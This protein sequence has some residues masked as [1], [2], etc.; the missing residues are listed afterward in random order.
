MKIKY[1]RQS[2]NIS[3]L[4]IS[5]GFIIVIILLII[6]FSIT[7]KNFFSF[8]NAIRILHTI[9]PIL[10]VSSGLALVIMAGKIDISVGSIAFLSNAIGVILLGRYH[11]P[12]YI[13][14]PSIVIVG[15]ILGALNGFLIVKLKINP[16]IATIGT[17]FI[18]RGL[19]LQMTNS[20]ILK[21]PEELQ[22]LGF[23]RVGIIFIDVIIVIFILLLVHFLH[24]RTSFGRHIMAIGNNDD[25]SERLGIKVQKIIFLSFIISGF[26]ASLGGIFSLFQVG[27][28]SPTMGQ[29]YEFS[30]IAVCVIG[31]ISLSG[32]VGS[33]IPGLLLGGI[34]LGVIENGLNMVGAS[35]YV[36]PFVKSGVIFIA[37]YADSL[38]RVMIRTKITK[39]IE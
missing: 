30:A 9:A 1:K 15:T 20:M 35:P 2:L 6:V 31:G 26:F 29:G 34:T 17:M 25:I 7:A 21:I 24:I 38:K 16:I 37:M 3:N 28:V 13:A 22:K 19:A 39:T 23:A 14:L 33:I 36:Y 10:I 5:Q 32:G 27:A 4:I 8:T 11:I 18:F 12:V